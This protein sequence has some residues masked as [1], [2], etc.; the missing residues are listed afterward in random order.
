M[1]LITK[2]IHCSFPQ[3]FPK[4]GR[5]NYYARLNFGYTVHSC[6]ITTKI[7]QIRVVLQRRACAVDNIS[8]NASFFTFSFFY[9]FLT[10]AIMKVVSCTGAPDTIRQWLLLFE[11]VAVSGIY[12]NS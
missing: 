1:A 11:S 2:Y 5:E 9:F 7:S 12:S 6:Y 3:C 8:L 4:K 10:Y